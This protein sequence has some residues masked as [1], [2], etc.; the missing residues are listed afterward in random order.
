[1]GR[2]TGGVEHSVGQEILE[3][4]SG[5]GDLGKQKG[6]KDLM[7]VKLEKA[8]VKI[9]LC[10]YFQIC[11]ISDDEIQ[12]DQKQE[13][14]T[15]TPRFRKRPSPAKPTKPTTTPSPLKVRIQK[16]LMKCFSGIC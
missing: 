1:M 11:F 12:T 16:A 4:D 2:E 13:R 8:G 3:K 5:G 14:Q 9:E 7:D 6:D 15:Y 10:L